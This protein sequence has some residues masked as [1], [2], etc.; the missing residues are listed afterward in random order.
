V[1]RPGVQAFA[2][3]GVGFLLAVVWFDLMFDVQVLRHRDGEVPE[4]VLASTAAYYR[5]VTTDAAP[6][7]LLVAVAMVGALA[8][9]IVELARDL[10]PT[11]VGW[12]SL[13][14]LLVPLLLARLRT[15]PNAVRLGGRADPAPVQSA[16]ARVILRDH[17]VCIGAL[18][19]VLV[20]QLISVL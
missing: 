7:N 8:A 12:A 14:L 17:L 3:T 16:L 4:P 19:A 20:I 9:I 6:M 13:G 11:W 15:V 2:C 18:V 5:R 1:Y 10:D